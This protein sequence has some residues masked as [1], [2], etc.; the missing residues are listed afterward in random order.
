MIFVSNEVGMGVIPLGKVA[1]EF[2]DASGWLHQELS[3]FCQR[4]TLTVSGL[5]VELKNEQ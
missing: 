4:V 1:R 5:S 3:E 2:V